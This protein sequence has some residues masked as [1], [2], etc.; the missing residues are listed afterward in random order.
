MSDIGPVEYA[1]IA[2]PGTRFTGDVAPALAELVQSQTIRV[3]DVAFAAKD[4]AGEIVAFEVSDLHPDLQSALIA[5]GVSEGG[6]L[7]DEDLLEIAEGLD[8]DSSAML[9]VWED[10]WASRFAAAVRD[11]DGTVVTIDRVPRE[12]VLAAR[13]W[14]AENA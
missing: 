11:A 5:A 14:A 12:L 8:P 7:S 10:L 3:I 1:I 4:A 13:E 9:I 2:F 6:L